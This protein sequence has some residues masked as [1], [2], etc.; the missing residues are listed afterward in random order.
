MNY[1]LL[2]MDASKEIHELFE[3][4]FPPARCTSGDADDTD[5]TLYITDMSGLFIIYAC[6]MGAALGARV[7]KKYT[8]QANL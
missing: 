2:Q 5:D 7:T 1:A 6:V 3:R 8:Q 4:W